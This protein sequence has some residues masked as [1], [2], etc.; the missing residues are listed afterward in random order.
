MVW[1]GVIL[2]ILCQFQSIVY[3]GDSELTDTLICV[4]KT[5]FNFSFEL[6]SV[7]VTQISESVNSESPLA[8]LGQELSSKVVF[9]NGKFMR[10]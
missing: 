6:K 9:M 2:K 4:T 1:C 3:R 8:L 10:S 7:I 5:D